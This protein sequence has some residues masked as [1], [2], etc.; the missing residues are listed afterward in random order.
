MPR[1]TSYNECPCF[2]SL[3]DVINSIFD[4]KLLDYNIDDKISEEEAFLKLGKKLGFGKE[5]ILNAYNV[6]KREEYKQNKINYLLQQKRL[7][8]DDKKILLI[9]QEYIYE[10]EIILKKVI[11]PIKDKGIKVIYSNNINPD[12]YNDINSYKKAIFNNIKKLQNRVDGIVNISTKPCISY[13]SKEF[14]K[15]YINIRLDNL[16]FD[17][18]KLYNFINDIRNGEKY[19]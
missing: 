7:E 8:N 14:N 1:I 6:A 19:E 18:N 13:V 11:N 12:N 5:F 3:Y 17:E 4:A 9:S 10:D 16:N 2:R 15:K